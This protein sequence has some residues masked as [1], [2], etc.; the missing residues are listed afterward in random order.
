MRIRSID[1]G[2]ELAVDIEMTAGDEELLVTVEADNGQSAYE[3]VVRLAQNTKLE[4]FD[5]FKERGA[6]LI[7]ND[8]PGYN[9]LDTVVAMNPTCKEG[10]R[11][12]ALDVYVEDDLETFTGVIPR[13]K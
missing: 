9:H 7:Y 6:V 11:N 4:G 3:G 1:K 13:I 2:V 10:E 5:K 12:T 8:N